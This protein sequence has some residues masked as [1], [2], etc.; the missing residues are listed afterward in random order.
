MTILRSAPQPIEKPC[1][2]CG[3]DKGW[4]GPKYVV[5]EW[6]GRLKF[7]CV[8][9]GYERIEPTKDAPQRDTDRFY[10][11][12]TIERGSRWRWP[13]TWKRGTKGKL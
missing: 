5:Y 9:C 13:W 1:P 8:T 10:T 6:G 4:D 7:A 2:K 12:R 3:S 11:G